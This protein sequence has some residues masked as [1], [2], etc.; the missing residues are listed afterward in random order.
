MPDLVFVFAVVHAML[1]DSD[2]CWPLRVSVTSLFLLVCQVNLGRYQAPIHIASRT[3]CD[4]SVKSYLFSIACLSMG[5][6]LN[7][8]KKKT[9]PAAAGDAAASSGAQGGGH[10]DSQDKKT[11]KQFAHQPWDSNAV[12]QLQRACQCFGSLENYFI[13]RIVVRVL[14]PTS[15]FHSRSPAAPA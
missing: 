7:A 1:R 11:L 15:E 14:H 13:Q 9:K 3:L 12:N 8:P 2:E 4:F 6:S 10:D 5:L